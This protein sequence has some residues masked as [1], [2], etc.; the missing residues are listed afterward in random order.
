M[1][2][3]LL[4][5]FVFLLAS[6]TLGDRQAKASKSNPTSAPVAPA[7]SSGSLPAAP[8]TIALQKGG[9]LLHLAP[10]C[11]AERQ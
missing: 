9:R 5:V 1:R 7:N 4:V 6:C 2:K 11:C 10:L 3:Y 8:A